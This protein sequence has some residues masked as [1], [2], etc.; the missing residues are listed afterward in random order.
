MNNW[1]KINKSMACQ[2]LLLLYEDLGKE[3][4]TQFSYMSVNIRKGAIYSINTSSLN[5]Y[6]TSHH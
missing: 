4:Q 6:A 2:L 3:G 1:H 5:F